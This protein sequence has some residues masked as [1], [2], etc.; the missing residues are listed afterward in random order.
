MVNDDFYG[1]GDNIKK[2]EMMIFDRWGN[3][4]FFADDINK[5]WDGIANHGKDVAQQDVYVYSV[6]I[7]DHKD[8]KHKYTGTVTI[9]K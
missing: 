7:T 3:M 1:K 5:H 8:K 4:I 6:K 9:V 2:F